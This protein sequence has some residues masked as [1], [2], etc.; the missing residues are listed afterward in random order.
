MVGGR[1]VII[2]LRPWDAL[3]PPS[4]P[5]SSSAG[6]FAAG[7]TCRPLLQIAPMAARRLA[8]GWV[9]QA[10]KYDNCESQTSLLSRLA[11]Q[12]QAEPALPKCERVWLRGSARPATRICIPESRHTPIRNSASTSCEFSRGMRDQAAPKWPRGGPA[13]PQ[14]HNPS[15]GRCVA[16]WYP[17]MQAA[18]VG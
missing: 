14:A 11:K 15:Q 4:P 6:G 16:G 5:E 8:H 13:S 3:R 17:C 2:L 18:G 1:V 12:R 7:V 9:Q 10:P